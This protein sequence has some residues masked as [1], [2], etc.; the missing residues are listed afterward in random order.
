MKLVGLPKECPPFSGY[1]G[2]T[3]AGYPIGQA[4]LKKEKQT[5]VLE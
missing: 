4:K 1:N 5:S 2:V 3:S